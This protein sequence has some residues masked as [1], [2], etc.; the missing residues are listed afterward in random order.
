MVIQLLLDEEI[1]RYLLS[2]ISLFP[3]YFQLFPQEVL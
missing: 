2:R 1:K 3:A